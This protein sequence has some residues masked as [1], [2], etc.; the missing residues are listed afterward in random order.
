MIVADSDHSRDRQGG[1]QGSPISGRLGSVTG[2]GWLCPLSRHL[3]VRPSNREVGGKAVVPAQLGRIK[4]VRRSRPRCDHLGAIQLPKTIAMIK[5]LVCSVI[6]TDCDA[7]NRHEHQYHRG[8]LCCVP[9][10]PDQSISHSAQ[11]KFCVADMH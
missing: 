1:S 4:P 2:D 11:R 9:E 10:M 6:K 3:R 8:G 5:Y 7:F